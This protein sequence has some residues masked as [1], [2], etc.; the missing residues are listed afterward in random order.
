MSD[1]VKTTDQVE[2]GGKTANDRLEKPPDAQAARVAGA[3]QIVAAQELNPNRHNGSAGGD[4][5][6]SIQIVGIDDNGQQRIIAERRTVAS[7][8]RCCNRCT[9][10]SRPDP[11]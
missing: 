7:H 9:C 8:A 4:G 2:E 1:Q 3:D 5:D 6:E 10:G 11:G